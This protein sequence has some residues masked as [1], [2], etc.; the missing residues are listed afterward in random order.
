MPRII[1]RNLYLSGVLLM[2]SINSW[3]QNDVKDTLYF[4]FN[5][6]Y[7]EFKK[8]YDGT[9]TFVFKKKNFVTSAFGKI[10][11][12][13]LLFF[14]QL[15]LPPRTYKLNP[16]KIV[17]LKKFFRKNENLFKDTSTKKLDAYKIMRYFDK[18]I[19][20]FEKD[21]AFIKVSV[22]LSLSE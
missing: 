3:S 14:T 5:N 10:V 21:C 16:S 11:K 12:E 1:M 17:D 9:H 6:N 20:F 15:D 8:S 2:I 13:D 7:I 19:V 22:S 4:K 18:H